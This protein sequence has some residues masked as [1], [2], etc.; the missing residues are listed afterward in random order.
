M[1][2]TKKVALIVAEM[3]KMQFPAYGSLYFAD[4]L[5]DPKSKIEFVDGFCIG[6]HCGTQYWDCNASEAR[7]YKERTPHRGLCKLIH[8]VNA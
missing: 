1:L 3:A 7:F 6:L 8:V 4:A 2:C 5:L